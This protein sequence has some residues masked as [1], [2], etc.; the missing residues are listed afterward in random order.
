MMSEEN[1]EEMSEEIILLI[2]SAMLK[3]IDVSV[4]LSEDRTAGRCIA[5]DFNSKLISLGLIVGMGED[6]DKKSKLDH[7]ISESSLGK[8]LAICGKGVD[9]LG[10]PLIDV[11]Q[12]LRICEKSIQKSPQSTSYASSDSLG[13]H[14]SGAFFSKSNTFPPVDLHSMSFS[15]K[16][17]ALFGFFFSMLFI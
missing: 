8:I 6:G 5:S 15:I 11:S 9:S 10:E 16:D 14:A 2:S 12:F 1:N 3:N 7:A 4:W 17:V 13:I